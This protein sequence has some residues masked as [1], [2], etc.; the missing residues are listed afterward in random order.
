MN[1]TCI[2]PT[3]GRDSVGL[4][5]ISKF[6]NQSEYSK[7]EGEIADRL[8]HSAFLPLSK[9]TSVSHATSPSRVGVRTATPD[10]LTNHPEVGVKY[11]GHGHFWGCIEPHPDAKAAALRQE[12]L[13]SACPA[14]N[15]ANLSPKQFQR[16]GQNSPVA[17]QEFSGSVAAILSLSD[18]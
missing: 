18:I 7:I 14:F 13:S 17:Q 5:Q 16:V 3:S 11:S 4:C 8:S 2:F 10:L 9:L 15:G 1:V 6:A 12:G